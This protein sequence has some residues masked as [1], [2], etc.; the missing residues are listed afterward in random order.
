MEKL[1]VEVG[2]LLNCFKNTSDC[3][4]KVKKNTLKIKIGLT[5]YVT[6]SQ[7][8]TAEEI[9]LSYWML[10]SQCAAFSTCTYRCSKFKQINPEINRKIHS[11]YQCAKKNVS[12]AF[13]HYLSQKNHINS[14]RR[15]IRLILC[16]AKEVSMK[17]EN[18][19]FRATRISWLRMY[20][21]LHKV[22]LFFTWSI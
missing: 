9:I 22:I 3:F 2:V 13:P 12:N 7:S 19:T 5:S 17:C 14:V 11:D 20:T 4:F 8:D 18:T 16:S 6:S 21:C 1:A 15:L 10:P